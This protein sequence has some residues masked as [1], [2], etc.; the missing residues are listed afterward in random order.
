MDR[1]A[2]QLPHKLA[3]RLRQGDIR[4]SLYLTYYHGY[5]LVRD[6]LHGTK[7]A[8]S[9][10]A[11]EVGGSDSRSTGNFPAHPRIAR[12]L[13]EGVPDR[14]SKTLLDVGCGSGSLLDVALDLGFKRA[15]GIELFGPV[16]DRARAN[17]SDQRCEVMVG[18]ALTADLRGYD[19]LTLYNPFPMIAEYEPLISRASPE[20]VLLFNL[21]AVQLSNYV[22]VRSYTHP[23]YRPF[24][25]R[26]L[27][28]A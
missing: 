4:N 20:Y 23:I 6:S 18:D 5:L 27:R 22:V 2:A 3:R 16:A 17:I 9:S 7:Y 8:G 11:S 24:T 28:R 13:L 26:L 21:E 25:G 1:N 12:R 10:S 15:D 19:V 14:P